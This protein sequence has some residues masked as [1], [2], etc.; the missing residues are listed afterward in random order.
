MFPSYGV[1]R[2]QRTGNR[3]Q[4]TGNRSGKPERRFSTVAPRHPIC[5]GRATSALETLSY[6]AS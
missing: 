4:R 5:C 2:K 1:E 3:E 6:I